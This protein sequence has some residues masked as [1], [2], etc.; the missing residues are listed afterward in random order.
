MFEHIQNI[1]IMYFWLLVCAPASYGL[2]FSIVM[3]THGFRKNKFHT[4]EDIANEIFIYSALLLPL[5]AYTLYQ[6]GIWIRS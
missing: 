3:L 1:L 2:A 6:F 4:A 5:T